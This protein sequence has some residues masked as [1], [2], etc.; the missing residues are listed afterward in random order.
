MVQWGYVDDIYVCTI[1][2]KDIVGKHGIDLVKKYWNLDESIGFLLVKKLSSTIANPLIQGFN[3]KNP[4]TEIE[5]Y[6]GN[7]TIDGLVEGQLAFEEKINIK[8]DA[9]KPV[10]AADMISSKIVI[11]PFAFLIILVISFVFYRK[12]KK[13]Q[14]D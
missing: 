12:I 10:S 8:V 4:E 14:Q 2:L 6:N 3:V 7:L 5:T 13:S 9:V 11:L 1:V